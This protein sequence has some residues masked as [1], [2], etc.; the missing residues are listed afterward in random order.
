M[1]A[2]QAIQ[3]EAVEEATTVITT[4]E[5]T[6]TTTESAEEEEQRADVGRQSVM[7]ARNWTASDTTVKQAFAKVLET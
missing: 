4:A 1:E 2:T 6:T 5:R 3:Q 7:T